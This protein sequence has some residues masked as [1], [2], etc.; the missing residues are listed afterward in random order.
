MRNGGRLP[1]PVKKKETGESVGV[2]VQGHMRTD[3]LGSL[4]LISEAPESNI[5]FRTS[6]YIVFIYLHV[7]WFLGI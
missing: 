2:Q 7:T 3:R 1:R 6:S 5:F 4:P